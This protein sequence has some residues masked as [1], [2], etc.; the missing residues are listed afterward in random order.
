M[1]AE[2]L[3]VIFPQ[4][5]Y[6]ICCGNIIDKTRSYG[7]CDHCMTHIRWNIDEPLDADGMTVLKCVEYGIYERSV[8]FSL[9][10]SGHRYIARNIGE[11]M[12]DRLRAAGILDGEDA[13]VV[14]I[15]LHPNKMAVRGYNQS[16]LIA[17][18]LAKRRGWRHCDKAVIRVRETLPMRGLGSE[19]RENNASGSM[20]AGKELSLI[21]GQNVILVDDFYTTGSTARECGRVIKQANPSKI[22]M[23]A[24]AGRKWIPV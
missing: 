5:L 18:H 16:Q 20:A 2:I 21:N 1:Y 15:P 3:D 13:V 12:D 9:K 14:P 4:S 22:V 24:Y 8:I 23:L 11:I 7:I 6:C 19:E 17:K 10:Y